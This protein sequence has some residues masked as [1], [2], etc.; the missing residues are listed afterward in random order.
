MKKKIRIVLIIIGMFL[1][2]ITLDI[3][4]FFLRNEPLF[5]IKKDK[6]LHLPTQVV[7]L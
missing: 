2:F 3:L 1:T 5:A 7:Y 6:P 4:S